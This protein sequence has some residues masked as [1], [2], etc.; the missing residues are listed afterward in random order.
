[1]LLATGAPVL[2]APAMN[3][4]M[5]R[6]PATQRNLARLIEDGIHVA[7]PNSGEMAEAG[8]SG[9]GRMAE[10]LEIVAALER[11]GGTS[12]NQ[13]LAGLH[14]LV[15]SGPTHEPIDPVRYIANRSSGRQGHAIASAAARLGARVTLVSGPVQ[16]ADPEGARTVHV[17]TAEQMLEAVNAALPADIGVFAAAV[18]DWRM[19]SM[20]PE[21]LKKTGPAQELT[22]ELV[23][24]PDIL[25]T[26]GH[27]A[28]RPP[29]VIGFAAETENVVAFA[30]QKRIAKGCDWIVANDVSPETG[31][32]GGGSNTVHL[33]MED[34]VEDW[35]ELAKEDVADRLMRRAGEEIRGRG[36]ETA[37]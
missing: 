19:P 18:A 8:E 20:A 5:W 25:K 35:P 31:I 30:R 32:M 26:I 16:L 9:P 17:E 3:P 12:A 13:P 27:G 15:T 37:R 23:Q 10:P 29:L 28:G 36:P 11:L 34:S 2:I 14:V 4:H 33:V 7:G 22:L 21:K 1:V 6:A 24:N